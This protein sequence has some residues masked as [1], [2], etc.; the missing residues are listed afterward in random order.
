MC[1]TCFLRVGGGGGGCMKVE[2]SDFVEGQ[3]KLEK[4]FKMI[5]SHLK[6]CNIHSKK[7]KL[8][9]FPILMKIK[10][11]GAFSQN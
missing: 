9:N 2:A 8:L 5:K 7:I 1:E 3:N 4:D 10:S 6:S 11:S